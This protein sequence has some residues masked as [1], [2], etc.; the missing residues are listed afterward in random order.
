MAKQDA[1]KLWEI[2]KSDLM[3]QFGNAALGKDKEEVS[4]VRDGIKTFNKS[5]PAEAKGYAITNDSLK[6]SVD[7][8][9]KTRAYQEHGISTKTSEI[10]VMRHVDKLF[11][12]SQR[13][14]KKVKPALTP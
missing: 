10:P 4:K 9:A 11:P 6:E 12:E 13:T 3:R 2:R 1:T 7:Q 14:L 5:L 8:K